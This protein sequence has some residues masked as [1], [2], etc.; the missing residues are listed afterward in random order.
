MKKIILFS[1]ALLAFTAVF[2]QEN[3]T[4]EGKVFRNAV[5]KFL[6]DEGFSPTIDE[7]V[8]SLDFKKEGVLYWFYFYDSKPIY[9]RMFRSGTDCANYTESILL[10]AA[11]QTNIK[12]RAV[13]CIITDKKIANF[14]AEFYV[15]SVE[16]FKYTFYSNMDALK[17]ADDLFSSKLDEYNSDG[18][19]APFKIKSVSV[20]NTD[21]SGN[22]ITDFDETIYAN[23][24]Q[25]I[26]PKLYIDTYTEGTY[27]IYV[28][29]Y[30]DNAL[31]SATDGSSP[32][33][34]SY[35]SS[36]KMTKNVSQYHVSG[37]GGSTSGHWKKGSYRFEFY[38][39]D[40]L[41]F[42]KNFNVL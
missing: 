4:A 32:S 22:V 29:F 26:K 5:K 34:Y 30:F 18:S 41:L 33:G 15:N 27:D 25:Y 16:D 23:Q 31:S 3:I 10:K 11:N 39:K 19:A 8:H 42:T 14:V 13:K 36:L 7:E 38:Y 37:W 12:R 28:K 17:D 21:V 1:V 24:T 20:A 40:K 6:T 2:A 35:K 9:V